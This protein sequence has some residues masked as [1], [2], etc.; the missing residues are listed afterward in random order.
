MDQ[1]QSFACKLELASDQEIPAGWL[2]FV[3]VECEVAD[4]VASHTRVK[5]LGTECDVQPQ[6]HLSS[7]A[8]YHCQVTD[9]LQ[10]LN[11]LFT[12]TL[13]HLLCIFP[14]LQVEIEKKLIEAEPQKQSSCATQ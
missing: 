8:Y 5:S 6:K 13:N 2:P 7:R 12:K 11:W 9:L 3:S 10:C 4:A 1:P 14:H